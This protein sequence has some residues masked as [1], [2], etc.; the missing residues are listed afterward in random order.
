MTGLQ[1]S[2]LAVEIDAL[3]VQLAQVAL[4]RGRSSSDRVL[5]EVASSLWSLQD[6]LETG[7][8]PSKDHPGVTTC[9]VHAAA[10]IMGVLMLMAHEQ[11]TLGDC[12]ADLAALTGT[13]TVRGNGRG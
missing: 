3:Q 4:K 8:A 9:Q 13:L 6:N 11:M 7:C 12:L 10:V 1:Q 5:A 2:G